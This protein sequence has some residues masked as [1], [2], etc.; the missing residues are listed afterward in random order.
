[1]G[2]SSVF[3]VVSIAARLMWVAISGPLAPFMVA[4]LGLIAL[5][6]SVGAVADD[7]TSEF[8]AVE[9]EA[10][11]TRN[12]IANLF[13][14]GVN[15]NITVT[16][17]PKSIEE[18][19]NAIDQANERMLY[20]TRRALKGSYWFD[21]MG[22]IATDLD[23]KLTGAFRAVINGWIDSANSFAHYFNKVFGTSI[24]FLV[25]DTRS[26]VEELLDEIDPALRLKLKLDSKDFDEFTSEEDRG[27]LVATLE[28]VQLIK[29]EIATTKDGLF[30]TGFLVDQKAIKNL[31]GDL[32][33]A[34]KQ[35]A[36]ITAQLVRQTTA[37]QNIR[38]FTNVY[39]SV[40]NTLKEV[41]TLFG[42]Q[43]VKSRSLVEVAG[44]N[45]AEQLKYI[46]LSQQAVA[47]AR[48]RENIEGGG[49]RNIEARRDALARNADQLKHINY[50]ISQIGVEV[51]RQTKFDLVTALG[52]DEGSVANVA[53]DTLEQIA[54]VQDKIIAK[55]KIIENLRRTNRAEDTGLI[56]KTQLEIAS[57]KRQGDI[58]VEGAEKSLLSMFDRLSSELTASEISLDAGEFFKLPESLQDRVKAYARDLEDN[59]KL[60]AAALGDPATKSKLEKER[61]EINRIVG[62]A[63]NTDVETAQL[64]N[65]SRA[66]QPFRELGV[67]FNADD[68][69]DLGKTFN[70]E[71]IAMATELNAERKILEKESFDES[72][73]GHNARIEA[74]AAFNKKIFDLEEA[75]RKAR[76]DAL[77]N[78]QQS[79][80]LAGGFS[81]SIV[82]ALHGKAD[83]GESMASLI[84]NHLQEGMTSRIASFAEGFLDSFFSAFEGKGGI[85][86]GL[87]EMLRGPDNEEKDGLEAKGGGLFDSFGFGSDSKEGGDSL[88]EDAT[89]LPVE[90]LEK[91]TGS[92]AQADAG[93]LGWLGSVG[94]SIA[95][96]LG[97]GTATAVASGTTATAA[98]TTLGFTTALQLATS[99][100]FALA[101]AATTAS[102]T[103]GIGLATGGYVRGPGTGTSDSIPAML[104]NGEYVINAKATKR[105]GALI[106]AINNGSDIGR[107]ST[108]GQVGN[109]LPVMSMESQTKRMSGV[110]PSQKGSTTVNLQVT[111]DVTEATR[112]A[113]RDMGNE[114]SQQVEGNFRE[115][116]VLNG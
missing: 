88:V 104:S 65:F 97:F 91:L 63:L 17:E 83:F 30:S 26:A 69:N 38:S 4:L 55:E 27:L 40:E 59:N 96:A 84:T 37:G 68:F 82:D 42:E 113:V 50:L 23:I 89:A 100:L 62:E 56:N 111:G 85:G 46:E 87:V 115:R 13:G 14:L 107:F 32:E 29:K 52:L 66:L 34:E 110:A 108:G 116:G 60:I 35:L 33:R 31:N 15:L 41:T 39:T 95:S 112:K 48:E 20:S 36:A 24:G 11:S 99:A 73:K 98:S 49:V 61:A 81:K 25:K 58:L 78:D 28:R 106:K 53:A 114:L 79:E 70:A 3:S 92:V 22:D 64:D 45:N 1:M 109:N 57:L 102:F 67:N 75:T 74:V 6:G 105:H 21:W 43:V 80:K 47:I 54:T 90:G 18:T 51:Q 76:E 2:L 7:T 8:K 77:L 72:T 101:N 103:A 44:L 12:A 19:F 16:P 86:G 93:I 94:S 10:H 9:N 5:F 71:I